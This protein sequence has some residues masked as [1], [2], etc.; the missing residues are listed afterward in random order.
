MTDIAYMVSPL[1][2]RIFDFIKDK[3]YFTATEVIDFFE[4]R[5]NT[6]S[7]Y[8]AIKKLVKDGRIK[9]EGYSNR[10]KLYTPRG[11]S[12]LPY[13]KN[14]NGQQFP[15]GAMLGAI[16]SA[17]DKNY[18]WRRV[19]SLHELMPLLSRLFVIAQ[20]DDPKDMQAAFNNTIKDLNEIRR[21][22]TWMLSLIDDT[23]KHP[24]MKGNMIQF[25][26]LFNGKDEA[27]PTIQE[28]NAFKV[29]YQEFMRAH[30][31]E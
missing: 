16:D 12:D 17:F 21:T 4:G 7:I 26:N 29:W 1:E 19:E 23:F 9:F 11:G 30:N 8:R 6:Q 15:L 2:D 20:F 25:K 28:I 22:L 5:E 27:M 24:A 3:D 18:N 13:F 10:K 14:I 31:A